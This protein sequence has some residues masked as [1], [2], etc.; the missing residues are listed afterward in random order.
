VIGLTLLAMGAAS[1]YSLFP[2][3]SKAQAIGDQEQKATQIATKM[4]EHIQLLSPDKLTSTYLTGMQLI[5]SNQT[6]SPYTFNNCPLDDATDFS[7]AKALKNGKGTLTITDLSYG[8]KLVRV[9]ITWKS[10]TGKSET[11]T[12]GTILGGYR[13]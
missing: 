8:S 9:T 10:V 5:D 11:V 4:L 1:F 7:P 2:V 13:S 3:I 12:T 6:A